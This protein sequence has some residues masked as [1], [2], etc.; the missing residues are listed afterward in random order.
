MKLPAWT[1]AVI[2]RTYQSIGLSRDL[3]MLLLKFTATGT[4]SKLRVVLTKCN[5]DRDPCHVIAFCSCPLMTS[6]N[7]KQRT[8]LTS[9]MTHLSRWRMSFSL[10]S[11]NRVS[12][13]W[14]NRSSYLHF[15]ATVNN[16][17][18]EKYWMSIHSQSFSD[19]CRSIITW[20]ASAVQRDK[21]NSETT[22]SDN[23]LFLLHL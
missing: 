1:K 12:K 9:V 5:L 17:D 7:H 8:C 10:S 19:H 23:E 16:C 21:E 14:P 18:H 11:S 6:G 4:W 2:K 13:R 20:S 22:S 15:P 3:P